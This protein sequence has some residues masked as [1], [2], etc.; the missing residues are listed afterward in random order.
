[1]SRFGLRKRLKKALG[2][3]EDGSDIVRHSVT[4]LMPDGTERVIEAEEHYS[5]LM[6]A[7]AAG[8][9]IS[10]G[11]RAGGTCP[12]GKCGLCR[13]EI[14]DAT[15]LSDMKDGERKSLDDHVA[16][17]E[18]EGRPREPGPPATPNTRLGCHTKILGSGGRV[19]VSA[20]FD[21][22]SISGE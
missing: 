16:G 2:R 1:M 13:V 14:E 11:R 15:G 3:G 7:D 12:D 5:L 21:P 8:M 17:T 19:R 9:T 10:T 20:L 22:G 18:H 4:Y 6:A